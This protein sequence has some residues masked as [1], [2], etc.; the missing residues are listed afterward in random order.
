MG[1]SLSVSVV[2]HPMTL[3]ALID[4]TAKKATRRLTLLAREFKKRA[5]MDI[6]MKKTN[7]MFVRKAPGSRGRLRG[8]GGVEA[9]GLLAHK[10][11]ACGKVFPTKHSLHIHSTY[12]GLDGV[13]EREDEQGRLRGV[14]G[15]ILTRVE[16]PDRSTVL[17][18]RMGGVRHE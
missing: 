8:Q 16:G 10:C 17:Q 1:P 11:G 9:P 2:P 4:S 18:T 13:E 5:D 6:S 7:A 12:M 14:E 15:E 3:E